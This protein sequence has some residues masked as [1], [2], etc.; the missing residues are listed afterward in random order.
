MK[1]IIR[2]KAIK[3]CTVHMHRRVE[4]QRHEYS[5]SLGFPNFCITTFYNNLSRYLSAWNKPKQYSNIK[6]RYTRFIERPAFSSL[7]SLDRK[8]LLL[9]PAQM[10]G[11]KEQHNTIVVETAAT[12]FPVFTI[13]QNR[14]QCAEGCATHSGTTSM[15]VATQRSLL[16]ELRAA[17][18]LFGT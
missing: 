10:K 14:R 2:S 7:G 3:Q 12:L 5:L 1:E 18:P 11:P 8:Y 4:V 9:S 13:S 17:K 6:N 16:S 15:S